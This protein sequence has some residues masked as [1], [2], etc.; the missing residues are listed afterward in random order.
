M[1][2]GKTAKRIKHLPHLKLKGFFITN[3]IKQKEVARALNISPV[4]FN[5]KLNGYL[6]FTFDEVER[7]CDLYGVNPDIFLTKKLTE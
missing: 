3:G 7:I 6:H 1:G 2:T 4:T 5:Q